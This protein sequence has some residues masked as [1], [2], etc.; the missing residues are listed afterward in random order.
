MIA[1]SEKLLQEKEVINKN[2]L[3]KIDDWIS[4]DEF[5]QIFNS[6]LNKNLASGDIYIKFI[7]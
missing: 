5:Q 4:S 2:K 3:I 7:E 1:I 6:L